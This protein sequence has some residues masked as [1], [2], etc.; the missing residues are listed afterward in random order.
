M[1]DKRGSIMTEQ[2][3]EFSEQKNDCQKMIYIPKDMGIALKA[4]ADEKSTKVNTL[5]KEAIIFYMEHEWGGVQPNSHN[6]SAS[7]AQLR[8]ELRENHQAVMDEIGAKSTG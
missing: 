5:I 4:R 7:I 6:L 8:R 2:K 1:V 3:I